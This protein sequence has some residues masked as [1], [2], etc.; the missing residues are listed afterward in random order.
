M[1]NMNKTNYNWLEIKAHPDLHKEVMNIINSLKL[2]KDIKILILAAWTWAFDNRL[3]DNWFN[4]IVSAEI[5]ETWYKYNKELVD[6]IKI[7]LNSKFSEQISWKYD[8]I[9]A[10]EIIEHV[11]NPNNFLLEWKKLLKDEKSFFIVSTPNLH[12]IF[13]RINF[14]LFWYP[15]YF[16]VKPDLYDHVS[17]IFDNIFEHYCEINNIII[18]N[19]FYKSSF[20]R[21]FQ[22]HWLRSYVYLL[23][24]L[25]LL[26]FVFVFSLF[27]RNILFWISSIYLLK[28]SK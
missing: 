3:I 15:N 21:H 1:K 14:L 24:I 10:M 5:N 16:I 8:L 6:F 22:I 7:D 27:N 4:N 23:L 26:P 19:R 2:S 28:K 12:N 17:P 25:L 20:F 18:N 9:I 11:Y 13:S